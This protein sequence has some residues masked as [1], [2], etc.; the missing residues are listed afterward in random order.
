MFFGRRKKK[1]TD[2]PENAAAQEGTDAP[3]DTAASDGAAAGTEPAAETVPGSAEYRR[4]HGP[5]DES[6]VESAEGYVDLGA[7]RIAPRE[8]LQ[9]RLEVEERTQ[10]VVAV[11]LDLAGNSLQLQA[12]AAPRSEGLWED[13]RGQIGTSVGSQGGTVEEIQGSFGT[14]VV[15]KLPAQAADGSKGYRVAR[16][17]G[18]DGPR[19]FLRGVFGGT[20]ALDRDAAKDLE[21]LFRNVVVVRGEQ[22]LPPRDLLQ[23][24]LPKDA[25]PTPGTAAKPALDVDRLKRGPE[26]T[27]IG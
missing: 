12:F 20:A 15:A 9:L 21:A 18:V 6:E 13:I 16:F 23:L 19:W 27:H 2:A 7:L 3:E 5:F 11:T 8:G 26:V 17:V 10:R 24:R 1:D 4:A 22:P 25:Q 14:E